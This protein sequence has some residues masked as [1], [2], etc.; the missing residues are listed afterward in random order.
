[1]TNHHPPEEGALHFP[2]GVEK[3]INAKHKI[4]WEINH[5]ILDS[6]GFSDCV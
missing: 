4:V 5:G 6:N 2:S 1:M 3:Y